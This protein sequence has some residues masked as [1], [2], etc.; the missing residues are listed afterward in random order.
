MLFMSIIYFGFQILL[1]RL[2]NTP[3]WQ[4]LWMML[5]GDKPETAQ[6]GG[7]D[8]KAKM[9][10]A[11]AY[12]ILGLKVGASKQQIS[13]AHRKLIQKN[14]PDHGGSDYLAAK[15]NLAKKTLLKK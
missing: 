9:T 5:T 13:E 1:R 12:D 10:E 15:I 2:S 8:N 11:E 4:S 14:H 6:Q 3:Q 7:F